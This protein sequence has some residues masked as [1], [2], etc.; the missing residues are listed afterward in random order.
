MCVKRC[1]PAGGGAGGTTKI[2]DM[3]ARRTSAQGGFH[4]DPGTPSN[5]KRVTILDVAELAGVSP[6]AVSKVVRSAYGVSNAMRARVNSAI[7]ELD[8]RPHAGA[9][10]MRGRSYTVG[11]VVAALDTPFQ[12][13]VAAS[14]SDVLETSD[15]QEVI[16][17]GGA[18]AD[19]QRR[20]IDALM[21]RQVDGLVLIAPWLD[22]GHI[23]E[24]AR[25]VPVVTV[26]LHGSPKHF[27]AVVTDER[28]GSRLVVD[29]LA[30]LGHRRIVHTSMPSN[31]W[32][33]EFSLSHT[34][35]REGFIQAMHRR[36]LEPV[37]IETWYSEEG[38][39]AAAMEAFDRRPRP[40]AVFAGADIAALGVIRAAEERGL[41][42][43]EDIALVGY[44]NIHT[45]SIGRISLT[46]IDESGT[47]TGEAAAKLLLERIAGRTQPKQYVIAPQLIVRGT[48]APPPAA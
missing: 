33:G 15:L 1:P 38:G 31:A 40:T 11:V 34:E 7:D 9:R 2:I 24:V 12:L 27:D 23:E 20:R 21:D 22:P 18:Q 14:I 16:M 36:G 17:V 29:H 4:E 5:G 35:R 19:R 6:S 37:V 39:Y 28:L 26:A 48:A 32:E 47:L 30:S 45:S 42:I 43:P 13:E 8:Y 3:T 25:R 41:R 10:A 44:D 46:T